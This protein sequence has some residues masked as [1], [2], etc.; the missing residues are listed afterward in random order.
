METETFL[1]CVAIT[2]ST[3]VTIFLFF[4]F[5][6]KKM[7]ERLSIKFGQ[8]RRRHIKENMAKTHGRSMETEKKMP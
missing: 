3:V 6:M 5:Q 2:I 1:I 8:Q 7:E 4:R